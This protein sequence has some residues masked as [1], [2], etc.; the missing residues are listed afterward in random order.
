MNLFSKVTVRTLLKPYGFQK[1][2][3]DINHYHFGKK[4]VHINT[5]SPWLDKHYDIPQREAALKAAA[6]WLQYAQTV[7]TDN[8][9][10][11]YHLP[12]GWSSSYPETSGYIIPTLNEYAQRT[13][14]TEQIFPKT[15]LSIP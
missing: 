8:G 6:D 14:K 13:G 15:T 10:G 5:I 4:P 11:T 9:F 7:Q 2:T 1:I 3:N 12:V